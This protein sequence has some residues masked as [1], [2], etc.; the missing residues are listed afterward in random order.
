[1]DPDRKNQTFSGI[2]SGDDFLIRCANTTT[3]LIPQFTIFHKIKQLVFVELKLC[4]TC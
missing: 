1:V 2:A 3:G 4:K